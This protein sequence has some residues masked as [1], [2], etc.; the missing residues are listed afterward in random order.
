MGRPIYFEQST[1]RLGPPANMT[2]EQC[3]DLYIVDVD[4][5]G[6][7]AMVSCW[8]LSSEEIAEIT[9]TG[10]LWVAVIGQNHPPIGISGT[11]VFDAT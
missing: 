1:R 6:F 8:E 5:S 3:D 11:N 2:E 9:R 4:W 10:R 7:P